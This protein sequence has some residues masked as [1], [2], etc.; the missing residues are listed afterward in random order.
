MS[1]CRSGLEALYWI[2]NRV[3]ERVWESLRNINFVFDT[4][5][6][7]LERKL[8]TRIDLVLRITNHCG[9]NDK[10]QGFFTGLAL[11][12]KVHH[13][14]ISKLRTLLQVNDFVSG[15]VDCFGR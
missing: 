15:I 3:C 14:G 11:T 9:Y 6:T 7:N 4:S 1:K 13:A 10:L 2:I 8:N 12:L 5:V